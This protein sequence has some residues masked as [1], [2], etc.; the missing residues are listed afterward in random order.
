MFVWKLSTRWS[1]QRCRGPVL[2]ELDRCRTHLPVKRWSVE[3]VMGHYVEQYEKRYCRRWTVPW[4]SAPQALQ[5]LE[6]L[7]KQVG[8]E[9]AVDAITLVFSKEFRW[10]TYHLRAL[11][12]EG[13]YCNTIVPAL[14]K[15][16]EKSKKGQEGGQW[17]G[18]WAGKSRVVSPE[19][20]WQI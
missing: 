17:S 8:V 3:A 2:K 4:E 1:V 7:V 6:K 9:E 20:F 11:G 13:F 18:K 10:M 14:E 16:H 19:E 12:N 5:P 15:M